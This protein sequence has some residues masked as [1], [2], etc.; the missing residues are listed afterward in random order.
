M[1]FRSFFFLVLGAVL[2]VT[3]ACGKND[4]FFSSNPY[5]N[6]IYQAPPYQGAYPYGSGYSGYPGYNQ[7]PGFHPQMP[8]SGYPSAYTPFLPIDYY[9]RNNPQ[10]THYWN[11]F[12]YQWQ[13]HC[14]QQGMSP[15]NFNYFWYTYVPQQWNFGGYQQLYTYFNQTFYYWMTPNV[16]FS[17]NLNPNTFWSNYSGYGYGP[18]WT[19]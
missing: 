3:S 5:G 10:M 17:Q 15:Y 18:A 2:L 14:S 9:M 6:G 8:S 11:G 16:Q 4:G 12:W 1:K 7:F 13:N 19:Y